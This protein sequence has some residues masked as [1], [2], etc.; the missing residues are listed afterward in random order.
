[1]IAVI[2]AKVNVVCVRSNRGI[3]LT[4]SIGRQGLGSGS[5]IDLVQLPAGNKQVDAGGLQDCSGVVVKG[6]DQRVTVSLANAVAIRII[7]DE[8]PTVAFRLAELIAIAGAVLQN[9]RSGQPRQISMDAGIDLH[10]AVITGKIV[11]RDRYSRSSFR[12]IKGGIH[13][14]C[15]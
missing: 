11:S 13:C 5:G 2:N 14:L 6:K 9:G 10:A 12:D 8:F 7:Q 4:A 3:G 15:V 1:M